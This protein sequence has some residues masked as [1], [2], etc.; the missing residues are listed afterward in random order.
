MFLSLDATFFVQLANFAIFFALLTVLFLRPVGRAIRKRR[1]YIDG[2][3]SDYATYQAQAKALREQ[4]GAIRS[5]AR[6]DA[7]QKLTKARAEATNEAAALTAS[8]T[9]RVQGIVE[10]AQR[11]ADAEL[12]SARA[13]EDRLVRQLS[14]LMVERS[15]GAQT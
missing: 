6:R 2:V 15:L 9:T 1:E 8:Y 3:A 14:D 5:Q 7:E 12:E 10:E 4:A 11:N 13:H